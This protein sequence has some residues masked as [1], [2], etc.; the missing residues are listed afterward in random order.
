MLGCRLAWPGD[1]GLDL[2]LEGAGLRSTSDCLLEHGLSGTMSAWA[3]PACP[4]SSSL[5]LPSRLS[6]SSLAEPSS[7]PAAPCCS[8]AWIPFNSKTTVGV[9][10]K[11]A[12]C[13]STLSAIL[14]TVRAALW[15]RELMLTHSY[16]TAVDNNNEEEALHSPAALDRS[17]VS[18]FDACNNARL[19]RCVLH[20]PSRLHMWQ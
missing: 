7:L 17:Q 5:L 20:V 9:I 16:L 10:T 1:V 19:N 15:N 11:K 2:R 8:S 4:A 18:A 6:S 14:H 3:A 12:T 13:L